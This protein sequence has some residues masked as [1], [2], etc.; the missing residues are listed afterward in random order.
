MDKFESFILNI[1]NFIRKFI[2]KKMTNEQ[3][4]LLFQIIKFGLVGVINT[5]V[6]YLVTVLCLVLGIQLLICNAIAFIISTACAFFLNY[7]FVFKS[8]ECWWR[9]LIKSYC[10]YAF[11]GI[12]LNS[13]LL[14]V[15]TNVLSVS[16]YLSPL[17]VLIITIPTNFLLNKF[18]AFKR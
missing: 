8:R 4:D 12:G 9:G 17:L 6:S 10:S 11:T 18:W 7:F 13:V 3:A 5:L 16:E 14:Y 2:F 15:L 1:I